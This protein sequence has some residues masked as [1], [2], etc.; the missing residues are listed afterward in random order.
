M[1]SEVVKVV[2][3]CAAKDNDIIQVHKAVRPLQSSEDQIHQAL[4][5]GWSIAQSKTGPLVYKTQF[6]GD[7]LHPSPPASTRSSDPECWNIGILL[8][9]RGYRRCGAAGMRPSVS[10]NSTSYSQCRTWCFHLSFEQVWSVLLLDGWMT[11][12]C[13]ISC[14]RVCISCFRCGGSLRT[15]WR[16]GC[17]SPVWMVCLSLP[18][19]PISSFDAEKISTYSSS[20]SKNMPFC[21]SVR[22]SA[23]SSTTFH[24][25]CCFSGVTGKHLVSAS[26]DMTHESPSSSISASLVP[27]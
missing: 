1:C 27:L 25:I 6:Y 16:I 5:C 7:H 17:E 2:V 15:G 20:N 10:R 12:F 22:S 13:F 21:S 26:T 11:S 8:V 18:V 3:K 24:S 19:L 9:C 4:E 23:L 14:R